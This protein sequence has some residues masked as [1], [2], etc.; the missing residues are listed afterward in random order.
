VIRKLFPV[1]L[2]P[3]RCGSC[4]S[5]LVCT[6]LTA[7]HTS[8]TGILVVVPAL[9]A[10]QG[11]VFGVCGDIIARYASVDHAFRTCTRVVI[12]KIP[13]PSTVSWV[14]SRN[15]ESNLNKLQRYSRV[16]AV[17]ISLSLT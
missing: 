9:W 12:I 2:L 15:V 7:H 13:Y 17:I 8:A 11:G 14:V 10:G 4:A 6:V 3:W 16:N 5:L 1:D